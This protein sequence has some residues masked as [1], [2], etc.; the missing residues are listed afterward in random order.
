[1]FHILIYELNS[2][3]YKIHTKGT[4]ICKVCSYAIESCLLCHIFPQPFLYFEKHMTCFRV[5]HNTFNLTMVQSSQAVTVSLK[6]RGQRRLPRYLSL[7]S[8]LELAICLVGKAHVN[9][10]KLNLDFTPIGASN[11]ADK[12]LYS[13]EACDLYKFNYMQF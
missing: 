7:L 8:I 1:L 3:V 4:N 2:R 12:F 13:Q 9:K 6:K 5:V 10:V 11:S